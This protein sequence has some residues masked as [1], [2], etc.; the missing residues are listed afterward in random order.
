VRPAVFFEAAAQI[1]GLQRL[2]RPT[3]HQ[4]VEWRNRLITRPLFGVQL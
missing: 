2:N 1:H 3:F 4:V